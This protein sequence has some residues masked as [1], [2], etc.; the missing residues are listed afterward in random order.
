MNALQEAEER[1]SL[2][3][4]AYLERKHLLAVRIMS[5]QRGLTPFEKVLEWVLA[6]RVYR[7]SCDG[8]VP[9]TAHLPK[10]IND[11]RL[12]IENIWHQILRRQ[13][14]YNISVVPKKGRKRKIEDSTTALI[15]MVDESPPIKRHQ[16]VRPGSPESGSS[17]N[18]AEI[19]SPKSKGKG[20]GKKSKK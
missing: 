5:L 6:G 3:A 14:D 11:L 9:I 16:E 4:Q 18:E 12:E 10:E 19:I 17:S 8:Y 1:M 7:R 20:K 13:V 2:L 15:E